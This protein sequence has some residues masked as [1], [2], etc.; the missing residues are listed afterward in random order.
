MRTLLFLFA[1]LLLL[2]ACAGEIQDAN[3]KMAPQENQ[4]Q[5]K[6]NALYSIVNYANITADKL[7]IQNTKCSSQNYYHQ[8]EATGTYLDNNQQPKTLY[9]QAITGGMAA[10]GADTY[11]EIC[12]I[13]AN[14][15][16]ISEIK[17]GRSLTYQSPARCTWQTT[18]P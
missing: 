4:V 14:Q 6:E 10:S 18:L 16:I 15:K 17:T 1:L 2:T 12:L 9:F 3:P 13:I 5:C 7:N 11:F 8:L